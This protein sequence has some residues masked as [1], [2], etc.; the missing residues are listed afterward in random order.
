MKLYKDDQTAG[1]DREKCTTPEKNR[2]VMVESPRG[3]FLQAGTF[4]PAVA[5][6]VCLRPRQP[7][8]DRVP[9]AVRSQRPGPG[10]APASPGVMQSTQ[11]SSGWA[12]QDI[13]TPA[14]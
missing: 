4:D 14:P 13:G 2:E 7:W 10:L 8:M 5:A 1:T 3:V 9:S 12:R 6:T 11:A